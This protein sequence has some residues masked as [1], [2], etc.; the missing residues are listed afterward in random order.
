MSFRAH[1]RQHYAVELQDGEEVHSVRSVELQDDALDD[2]ALP[3]QEHHLDRPIDPPRQNHPYTHSS[4]DNDEPDDLDDLDARS[5]ES[6]K[7][8]GSRS[9][10]RGAASQPRYLG[11]ASPNL[12]PS[13]VAALAAR[14]HASSPAG[15][16]AAL[17]RPN[18]GVQL[19][20]TAA[21]ERKRGGSSAPTSSSSS[22]MARMAAE[23]RSVFARIYFENH[24]FTSSTVFKLFGKTTVLDVRKSMASKIKIP[25]G[26]FSFYVI[27]VVFPGDSGACGGLCRTGGLDGVLTVRL[28]MVHVLQGHSQRGRCGMTSS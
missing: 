22:L 4:S 1:L 23:E 18:S 27:V 16:A 15:A 17:R 24:N 10:P 26:D 14:K 12:Q 6:F 21:Y 20:H 25:S 9:T 13:S 7:S 5:V 28:C 2:H 8:T 3:L 19:A 11:S